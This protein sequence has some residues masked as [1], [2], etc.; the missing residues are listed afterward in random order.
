[1]KNKI[2]LLALSVAAL[3]AKGV[4]FGPPTIP[5]PIPE[6]SVAS[7]ALAGCGVLGFFLCQRRGKR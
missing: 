7:L 3:N 1:M 4:T 6:P 5:I 2:I